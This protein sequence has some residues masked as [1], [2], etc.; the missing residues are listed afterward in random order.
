[1]LSNGLKGK[2]GKSGPILTE[3]LLIIENLC[4]TSDIL[5]LNGF[6]NSLIFLVTMLLMLL[7]LLFFTVSI[8]D[9]FDNG[10]SWGLGTLMLSFGRLNGFT[11]F[12]LHY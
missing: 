12:A 10:G 5:S 11:L 2:G 1:M 6:G 4:E 3:V 7:I 8:D 9:F